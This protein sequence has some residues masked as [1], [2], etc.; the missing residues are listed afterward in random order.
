MFVITVTSFYFFCNYTV[1]RFFIAFLPLSIMGE[2]VGGEV[3][4]NDIFLQMT[5]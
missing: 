5:G 1:D 2:G 4:G 3:K